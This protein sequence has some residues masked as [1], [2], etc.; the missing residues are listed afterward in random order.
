MSS[1]GVQ[2]RA[3]YVTADDFRRACGRFATGVAIAGVVDRQGTPHGLTVNSFTSVSLDP[4]LVLV[5]IAHSA[6]VMEAF[7]DARFFA[8]SV[9][10]AGQRALSE[11]FARKGHDRFDGLAWHAGE[12]GAPLIEDTLAEI[13]CAIRYRFTAGDHDLIVG[14]MVRAQIRQG[15]PLLYFAGRY[16]KLAAGH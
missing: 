2:D 9:L 10:A 16:R 11:R 1:E 4:P 5:A 12:T 14:E 15:E 13:E 3:G 7:R 6:S 8:V